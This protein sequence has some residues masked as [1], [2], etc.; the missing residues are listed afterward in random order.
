MMSDVDRRSSL[1][2]FEK[3]L[4]KVLIVNR[5]VGGRGFDLPIARFAI[6]LSPKRSEETMWQEML[7][8]RS[9]HRDSK[10]VFILY[11]TQTKEEE[12]ISALVESMNS[13]K[14]RYDLRFANA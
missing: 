5:Q 13:N 14:D 10:D 3:G 11:F 1:E 12:K 4:A 9:S 8:I 6:F 2:K 7:R